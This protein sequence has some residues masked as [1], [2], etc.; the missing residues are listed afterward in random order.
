MQVYNLYRSV[1]K[2]LMKDAFLDAEF[3]TKPAR[4]FP[5]RAVS[6]RHS[7]QFHGTVAVS[8]ALAA[9]TQ[10]TSSEPDSSITAE[11]TAWSYLVCLSSIVTPQDGG[12]SDDLRPD[13]E[14]QA[15]YPVELT[16]GEDVYRSARNVEADVVL[17]HYGH[18]DAQTFV[19]DG[20]GQWA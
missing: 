18:E 3:T 6:R 5:S 17:S 2:V 1:E 8:G 20:L 19:Q 14:R 12:L 16:M 7:L 4:M 9:C 11:T 15:G 13:F 10:D